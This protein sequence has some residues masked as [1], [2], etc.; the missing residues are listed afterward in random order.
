MITIWKDNIAY[1][2]GLA[3]VLIT[4][5]ATRWDWAYF[6]LRKPDS[7]KKVWLQAILYSILLLVFV[8]I[9]ITPFIESVYSPI[10][11]SGLDGIRGSFLN[12][13]LFIVFMWVIAAFGEEFIYRGLLINRLSHIWGNNKIATLL[14]ILLSAVLFGIAHRYQGVSGM[15]STGLVGF[16]LGVLFIQNR[17]R[18]WLTILTHGIYDVIGITFIYLDIEKEVYGMFKTLL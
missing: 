9:L 8:D 6:G 3:Y 2:V 13:A 14:A 15:L 18:L 7:W 1:F 10:D 17:N 5:W 4:L 11:L 16:I 12:Y